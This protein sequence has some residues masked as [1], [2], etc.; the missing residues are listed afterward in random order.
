MREQRAYRG[1]SI[2]IKTTIE[3]FD[4]LDYNVTSIILYRI[5]PNK[6][7]YLVA[8]WGRHVCE[9]GKFFYNPNVNNILDVGKNRASY[10]ID[11]VNLDVGL[12][13]LYFN[14]VLKNGEH[15]TSNECSF[16]YED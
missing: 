16:Y 10:D 4:P 5:Y 2:K 11:C 3:D 1:D 13:S 14:I 12:H 6:E 15:I 7:K 9:Y 8:F